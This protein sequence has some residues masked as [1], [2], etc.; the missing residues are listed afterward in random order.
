MV[1]SE[2]FREFVPGLLVRFKLSP[3]YALVS[4]VLATCWGLRC[5]TLRRYGY[6]RCLNRHCLLSL[7]R[8]TAGTYIES[9]SLL[10]A[11]L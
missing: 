7:L 1:E 5:N 8:R 6:R 9:D 4:S 3:M 10:R 2:L 11:I